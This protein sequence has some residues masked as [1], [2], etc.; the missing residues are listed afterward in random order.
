MESDQLNKVKALESKGFRI[1]SASDFLGLTPEEEAY[2]DI[3]EAISH[4]VKVKRKQAGWTQQ[5][6][7]EAMGSDQSRIAKLEKGEPRIS[8]D[9]M[10]RALLLLGITRKELGHYLAKE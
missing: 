8:I 7:A 1:G 5:Q 6:L 4:W 9:L 10:M 3:R 2:L